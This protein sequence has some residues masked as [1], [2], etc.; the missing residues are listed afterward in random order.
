MSLELLAKNIYRMRKISG[1]KQEEV[2]ERAQLSRAAYSA[3]EKGKSNAR[4]ETL[5]RISEALGV[6]IR[7]LFMDIPEL[8]SVR[9]RMSKMTEQKKK[10]GNSRL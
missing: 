5:H 9:F 10:N 2:A 8:K 7:E 3:I 6:N 1:L 4:S